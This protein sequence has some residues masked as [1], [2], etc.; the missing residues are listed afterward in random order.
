M[1]LTSAKNLENSTNLPF[2]EGDFSSWHDARQFCTGYD[3]SV[4]LEKCKHA[5]LQV[6]NGKAVY[7]R[8]AV[9]FDK[10][11]YNWVLLSFLQHISIVNNGKISILDFGGSLG[12]SY[13]ANYSF[14]NV[15]S[16]FK[17]SV[18][19]QKNF[20]ECG[21]SFFEDNH[22]KFYFTIS[23]CFKFQSPNIILISAALQYLEEPY[24]LLDEI[25]NTEIEYLILDRLS[26]CDENDHILT[27]QNVPPSFYKSTLAHW[28]FS[29][30]KI[31]AKLL[32]FFELVIE[33]PSF[34]DAPYI[35]NNKFNCYFNIL[36]FK[37]K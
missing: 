29:K 9:I 17:W 37:R 27:I 25:I 4:I 20:V 34:A 22:L 5:L 1:N 36:I 16:E 2:W 28:F 8:D 32:P 33:E 15:A 3:D 14:L 7:Q 31:L 6:K 10:I 35:L 18:V 23:E 12:S 13:Y 24:R 30:N 19:E 11:Q 21:K 26:L